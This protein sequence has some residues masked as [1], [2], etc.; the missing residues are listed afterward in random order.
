M[1]EKIKIL[2]ASALPF[3]GMLLLFFSTATLAYG[4]FKEEFI[5]KGKIKVKVEIKIK[6]YAV[7]AMVDYYGS[8]CRAFDATV[9]EILSPEKYRNDK[10]Y[11]YHNPY[12]PDDSPWREVGGIFSIELKER[13]FL[14][15]V[16]AFSG[17]SMKITPVE[18]NEK[19]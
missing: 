14:P 17:P 9:C 3:L 18:K 2:F 12:A 10:F 11:I 1:G 7:A 6:E 5:K 15:G 19:D 16:H 13:H 8:H 4:D